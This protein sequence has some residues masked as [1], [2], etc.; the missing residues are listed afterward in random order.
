MF[1]KK[2]CLC[3]WHM[4]R[5]VRISSSNAHRVK[6]RRGTYETLAS[7]MASHK[8]FWSRATSHGMDTEDIARQELEVA[9][10]IPVQQVGLVVDPD[11]PWL[12][13]SPD[14]IIS[15]GSTTQ[16]VEIKC[17]YL[18]KDSLLLNPEKEESFVS[19][20]RY[21][22]GQLT[23]KKTHAYYTQIMVMLYVLRL[24]SALLFVYSSQQS[25]AVVVEKDDA[26]LAEYVPK[27]EWFYFT[28][29]IRAIMKRQTHHG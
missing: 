9:L 19:F 4:E 21:V 15:T 25:I 27:L 23:L 16:L 5:Q 6:T 14:G 28:Y 18:L 12:C 17:P 1:I 3:R 11:Q 22:N 10:G 2:I 24:N 26:F 8:S 29:L 13:C 7:S 20:I